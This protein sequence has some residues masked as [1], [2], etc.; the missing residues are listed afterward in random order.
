MKFPIFFLRLLLSLVILSSSFPSAYAVSADA[1][2]EMTIKSISASSVTVGITVK[3]PSKQG[4]KSV[5][6]WLKYDQNILK[7]DK[8]DTSSSPFDMVAPGENAFDENTGIVK[9]GRASSSDSMSEESIAIA[10]VSFQRKNTNTTHISFYN[11]QVGNE[12]NTSVRVFEE[13]FP[14]NI[15]ASEPKGVDISGTKN[16]GGSVKNVASENSDTPTIETLNTRTWVDTTRPQGLRASAGEDFAILSWNP[17]KK[18]SGYN[19]YYSH[20]SGRYLQ[21]KSTNAKSEF[22]LS[23]LES[24]KRYFIAITAFDANQ[25]ETDYSNEI[26]IVTGSNGLSSAPLTVSREERILKNTKHH[27]QTGPEVSF[28]LSISAGA[29]ILF[30]LWKRRKNML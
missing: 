3:N 9:I 30:F 13:G 12:S 22:Y 21:R 18:A 8:I 28:A 1:T 26:S 27:V 14:V 17:L 25:K 5:Q 11:F 4:I 2:L 10:E 16:L 20:S 29:S 15:L 19:I 7:G 6:S 23:G 24:G